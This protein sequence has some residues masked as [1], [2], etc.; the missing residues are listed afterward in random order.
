MKSGMIATEA[1]NEFLSGK[2]N[3]LSCYEALFKKSWVYSELKSARNVKPF[4]TRF[5]NIMVFYLQES[6][7]G[8]LWES[9]LLL[10]RIN[11][12]IMKR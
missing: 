10:Y 2:S 11:M 9:F 4:F 1:I 5:G 6:I 3:D 7:S 12:L 8:Y